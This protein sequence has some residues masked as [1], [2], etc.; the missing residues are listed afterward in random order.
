MRYA[1]YTGC[2]AE[3]STSE[4]DYS[5][6]RVCEKLGIRLEKMKSASCCGASDI[7]EVNLDLSRALNGRTLALAERD[8][9]D[10]ITICN[11]CTL[12]LRTV[13]KNLKE[14]PDILDATNQVLGQIGMKYNG[15]VE[16]THFLWVLMKDFG[17]ERLKPFVSR[18]LAGLKVAPFYGCQILRP[19]DKL[20]FEDPYNPTSL[21][22]IIAALGADPVDY[23]GKTKCCAFLISLAREKTA[24]AVLGQQLWDGKTAGADCM[25]TPCPLCHISLDAFQ[26]M[27]EKQLGRDI[28]LPIFHL[29]Q[30]VGLAIGLDPAELK[31]SRHMVSL[32]GILA[33]LR[34]RAPAGVVSGAPGE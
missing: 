11:V 13:N 16:V 20:G 2:V 32:D 21:E 9:L 22:T 15:G 17:I 8:G 4:L 14:N 30:L 24:S 6:Q 25:V 27:A 1:Y 23:A 28:R 31:L 33:K 12:T 19:A 34:G 26:T 10:I 3:E 29:P 18:P 5:T 7:D